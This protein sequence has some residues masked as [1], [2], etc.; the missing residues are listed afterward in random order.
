MVRGVK[1]LHCHPVTL[2]F[3]FRVPSETL[4]CKVREGEQ[5]DRHT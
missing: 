5:L 3:P 1:R 4:F 2:C